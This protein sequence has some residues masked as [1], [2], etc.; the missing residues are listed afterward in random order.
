MPK[1][2]PKGASKIHG[3]NHFLVKSITRPATTDQCGSY[4]ALFDVNIALLFS[5][6]TLHIQSDIAHVFQGGPLWLCFG[7][8]TAPTLF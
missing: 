1:Q 2:T 8:E 5:Q 4:F 6:N 3:Q 7:K